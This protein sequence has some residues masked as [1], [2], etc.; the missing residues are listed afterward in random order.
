MKKYVKTGL[1]VAA[2]VVIVAALSS[3]VPTSTTT[4]SSSGSSSGFSSMLPMIGFLALIFVFFWFVMIRPQRKR[5]KEHQD[6]M[7]GLNKGDRV[8]TAGGLYGTIESLADDSV[9]LK[10]EGGQTIRVSRGS[11]AVIRDK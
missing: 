2:A 8:I 11:I 5:Q 1:I 3:C 9:V 6:M 7:Q 10:M 4:S